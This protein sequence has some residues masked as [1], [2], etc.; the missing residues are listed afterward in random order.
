MM[1]IIATKILLVV[2]AVVVIVADL[3]QYLLIYL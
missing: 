1:K 2:A 3:Y